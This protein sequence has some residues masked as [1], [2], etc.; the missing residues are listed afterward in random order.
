MALRPRL[1]PG[2]PLS[3]LSCNSTILYYGISVLYSLHT[4][5]D[6]EIFRNLEKQPESRFLGLLIAVHQNGA[7]GT[8]D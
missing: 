1:S 6:F 2:L 3:V 7:L 4:N 8:Q 5:L